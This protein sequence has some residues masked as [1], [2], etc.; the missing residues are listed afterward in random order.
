ML[1]DKGKKR[2]VMKPWQQEV[3]RFFN[4]NKNLRM[5]YVITEIIVADAVKWVKVEDK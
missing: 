5:M 3:D 2:E 4:F 1:T